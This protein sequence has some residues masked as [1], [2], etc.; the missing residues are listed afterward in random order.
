MLGCADVGDI[1][2]P[3]GIGRGRREVPLQMIPSPLRT[4][5]DGFLPP[6]PSLRHALEPSSTHQARHPV[7]ATPL[8]RIAEGFPDPPTPHDAV[9][10]SMQGPNLRQYSS[11]LLCAHTR[12]SGH[13]AVVPA[14]RHSQTAA[15]QADGKR[16]AAS[17]D[18]PLLHRD[19]LAKNAAASR[20]KSRA[21]V[22]RENRS[23]RTIC[24]S[25]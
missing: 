13:P 14:G 17:L 16:R 25:L 3:F 22:A 24:E 8:S 4:G 12:G 1:R 19:A 6:P 23:V 7:A 10:V 2:D 9:L 5:P 20:K 15:H 21:L 18:H 11:V